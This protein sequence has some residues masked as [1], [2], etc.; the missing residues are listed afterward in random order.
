MTSMSTN[1]VGL[2][3]G[4]LVA[5]TLLH[6]LACIGR[7]GRTKRMFHIATAR[8]LDKYEGE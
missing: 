1:K 2:V 8:L 5:S 7:F 3:L 4:A 6:G